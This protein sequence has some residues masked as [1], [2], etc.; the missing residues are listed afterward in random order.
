MGRGKEWHY[1]DK[2]DWSKV[3]SAVLVDV[4]ASR[5]VYTL[6]LRLLQ[7]IVV[8]PVSISYQGYAK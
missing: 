6:E 2:L 3:S 1:V 7:I 8:P 5:E 4:T